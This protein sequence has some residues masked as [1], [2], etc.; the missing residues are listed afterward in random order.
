[1][2][3]DEG[4]G[5]RYSSISKKVEISLGIYKTRMRLLGSKP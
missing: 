2:G 4:M 1:M 5:I 3:D